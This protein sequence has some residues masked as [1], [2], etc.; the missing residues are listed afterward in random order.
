MALHQNK[1]ALLGLSL[2]WTLACRRVLC[3]YWLVFFQV[4]TIIVC[5]NLLQYLQKQKVAEMNLLEGT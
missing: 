5:V 2:Q 4:S 1:R 3:S